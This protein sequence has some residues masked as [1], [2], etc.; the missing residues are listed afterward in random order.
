M[1]PGIHQVA[2]DKAHWSCCQPGWGG[3]CT[4]GA[5]DRLLSLGSFP[6]SSETPSLLEL[7]WE[8][9]VILPLAPSPLFSPP[10]SP[11]VLLPAPSPCPSPHH[12]LTRSVPG[13]AVHRPR[14]LPAN[15]ELVGTAMW[16]GC[17]VCPEP[18]CLAGE[19]LPPQEAEGDHL[20]MWLGPGTGCGEGS[21]VGWVVTV[22]CAGSTVLPRQ[23]T[24]GCC[25]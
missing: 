11:W 21:W 6:C 5:G 12:P 24:G 15:E 22:S 14:E 17:E 19:K 13:T 20:V 9:D 8:K 2:A 1:P 23:G 25:L 7:S 18:G 16:Q 4:Q 3:G 10:P